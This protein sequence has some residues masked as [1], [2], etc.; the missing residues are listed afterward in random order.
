M[1]TPIGNFTS[2]KYCQEIKPKRAEP[3]FRGKFT[4]P[5]KAYKYS[6]VMK[7]MAVKGAIDEFIL[8]FGPSAGNYVVMTA[9]AVGAIALSLKKPGKLHKLPEHIDFVKAEKIKDAEEFARD[10]FK[11]KIFQVD[12]LEI[13]NWLNEGLTN[14]SNKFKG[15]TYLPKNLA[16]KNFSFRKNVVAA[17]NLSIDYII[18]NKNYLKNLDQDLAASFKYT[19]PYAHMSFFSNKKSYQAFLN[20]IQTY[21]DEPKNMS[22]MDKSNLNL[23]LQ[24]HLSLV[25]EMCTNPQKFRDFYINNFKRSETLDD[26]AKYIIKMMN[27]AENVD[28]MTMQMTMLEGLK[29]SGRSYFGPVYYESFDTLYHEMGHLFYYKNQNAITKAENVLTSDYKRLKSA[30]PM[31]FELKRSRKELCAEAFAGYMKDEIYPE[32]ISD[33]IKKYGGFDEF[34]N[35]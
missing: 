30:V 7:F 33:F 1:I 14:I 32:P 18:F 2:R 5:E 20:S 21:I 23:N 29:T 9:G 16:L 31:S 34:F 13:A 4:I 6:S 10:V 19:L 35:K 8:N 11:V 15:Q 26:Y 25:V 22:I 27:E 12:N 3:N 17:Y 24:S 28:E